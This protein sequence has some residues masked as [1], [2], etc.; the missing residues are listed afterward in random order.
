MVMPSARLGSLLALI[1]AALC[2]TACGSSLGPGGNGAATAEGAVAPIGVRS[3]PQAIE[4]VAGDQASA[5]GP[6]SPSDPIG[7]PNAHAVSLVEVRHELQIE[8]ELNSL[9][10]GQGF[11]FPIAPLS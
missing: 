8:Q 9:Q 5:S 11:M 3:H 7:D 4:P 2:L 10:P 6:V 1:A